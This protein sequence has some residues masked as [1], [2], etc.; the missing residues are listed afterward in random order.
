MREQERGYPR[1]GVG[2]LILDENERA[3]LVLRK[4]SPEAGYWSI[5]G[6]KV[7]F[8]ETVEKALERELREE[9]GIE[10]DIIS[11]L[12]VTNHIIRGKNTHWVSPAFLVKIKGRDPRNLA[13]EETQEISWFSIRSLPKNV[14]ITTKSAINAYF[15]KSRFNSV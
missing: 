11:L 12:G 1:V 5:P 13:P 8:M 10:I 14:T 6:G 3:L 7:E 15:Q 9:L 4:K 2:A